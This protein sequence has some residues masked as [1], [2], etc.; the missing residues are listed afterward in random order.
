MNNYPLTLLYDESC[1]LCKLEID[2]LKS[3]NDQNLL[4]FV[5][6]SAPDFD[7]SAYKVDQQAVMAIIHAIR[8]D[9]SIVKGVEVFRLAYGA[10]GLGWITAPTNWPLLK[11]LSDW[12][13]VHIARNRY[14]ISGGFSWVFRTIAARRAVRQSQACK[15]GACAIDSHSTANKSKE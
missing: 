7:A 8:P 10:V 4:Q 3:R 6:A 11:P 12:A 1:P 14:L 9:G 5:D 15:D 13:Y 2:N